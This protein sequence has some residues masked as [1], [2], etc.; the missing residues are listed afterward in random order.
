MSGTLTAGVGTF[1]TATV[2]GL[3][4]S[5]AGHTHPFSA[6]T[7]TVPVA[8]GGLGSVTYPTSG[9]TEFLLAYSRTGATFAPITLGAADDTTLYYT[10]GGL[11]FGKLPIAVLNL[12]GGT[13]TFLRGDG[14]FA[15]PSAGSVSANDVTAGT[16]AG[17][18]YVFS[19]AVRVD[20][21]LRIPDNEY[22]YRWTGSSAVGGL[23][24]S[25]TISRWEFGALLSPAS[26]G[27]GTADSTTVL[28]GDNVWRAPA[29]A[30]WTLQEKAS[31][32]TKTSD[33]TMSSAGVLSISVTSGR[34]YRLRGVLHFT[35]VNG[36]GDAKIDIDGP[37]V[38]LLRF[39]TTHMV[40]ASG[41]NGRA[42]AIGAAI[43]ITGT[44]EEAFVRFDALVVPSA[45]GTLTLRWAQNTASTNSTTLLKGSWAEYRELT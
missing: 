32:E 7:G 9:Q 36:S 37:T 29:A 39:N 20:S 4:V 33:A 41:S 25:T 17:A 10:G 24:Y 28:H 19:N 2:G 5:V 45:S 23:R 15:V 22:L 3:A 14:T 38:T 31:D 44:A 13:T 42:T 6:I 12:P 18:S 34:S 30:A 8:Q 43:T 40:G 27:T 11:R 26:L 1:T 21:G 16:F 35:S